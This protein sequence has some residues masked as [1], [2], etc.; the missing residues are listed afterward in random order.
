MNDTIKTQTSFVIHKTSEDEKIQGK[1]II[2]WET[3][4]SKFNRKSLNLGNQRKRNANFV[5]KSRISNLF[6]G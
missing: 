5:Q 1:T 2:E 6:G 3:E 4:L